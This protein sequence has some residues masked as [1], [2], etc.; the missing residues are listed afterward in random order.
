MDLVMSNPH[1]ALPT[2]YANVGGTMVPIA[3]PPGHLPYGPDPYYVYVNGAFVPVVQAAPPPQLTRYAVPLRQPVPFQTVTPPP[4][5]PQPP[6]Q[7]QRPQRPQASHVEKGGVTPSGA[8]PPPLPVAKQYAMVC[9][10]DFGT[11]YSGY[12]CSWTDEFKN[13]KLKMFCRSWKAEQGQTEKTPTVAL[14]DPNMDLKYFGYEAEKRYAE[15]SPRE[16]KQWYLFQKFKMK[17]YEAKDLSLGTT[18]RAFN[19]N[20]EQPALKVISE[21]LKY[22]KKD[23]LET[24]RRKRRLNLDEDKIRWVITVPAIWS[25]KA[26]IF[27]RAAADSAGIEDENLMLALEPEAAALYC[28]HIKEDMTSPITTKPLGSET[29]FMVAD[30]G[31]GTTDITVYKRL[32][33]GALQELHVPTGGHWGGTTVDKAFHNMLVAIFGAEVVK[34]AKEESP[35]EMLSLQHNFERAKRDYAPGERKNISVKFPAIMGTILEELTGE[36][37][38]ELIKNIGPSAQGVS[39]VADKISIN[40]QKFETLFSES[41]DNMIVHL[42]D[43]MSR[44]EIFP[45]DTVVLVG[46][47]SEAR[48]IRKRFEEFFSESRFVSPSDPSMA[49]M[50]GAALFGH[51]PLAI[52][53]RVCKYTYGVAISVPFETGKHDEKKKFKCGD[54]YICDD[55]FD[56]HLRKGQKV[57]IGSE[58]V[59]KELKAPGNDNKVIVDVYASPKVNP[60][61]V[62]EDG[63]MRLGEAIITLSENIKKDDPIFVRILYAGTELEMQV[64]EGQSGKISRAKFKSVG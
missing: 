55:I 22:L 45:L 15:L 42:N 44:Q 18:I 35:G 36:T 48:I 60:V 39:F 64:T 50:K 37:P 8:V 58:Q 24:A 23:V 53:S 1:P 46:G 43:L 11:T 9:A 25:D 2:Y 51:E 57:A 47:Y 17:L 61:Y 59:V 16:R 31:G 21:V 32:E 27:M 7:P 38:T 34:T 29:K 49:V 28:R 30:L 4:P 26:K 54:E 12:V 41:L 19:R 3:V 13:D 6:R 63:C 56:I 14:F 10:I 52:T 40:D 5:L 62:T 33:R 20:D